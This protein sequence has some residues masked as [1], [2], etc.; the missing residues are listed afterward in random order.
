MPLFHNHWLQIFLLL[1]VLAWS[2]VIILLDNNVTKQLATS[3]QLPVA[4]RRKKG[5]SL[6]SPQVNKGWLHQTP[7]NAWD[8]SPPWHSN[9]CAEPQFAG[10]GKPSVPSI[11]KAF[12]LKFPRKQFVTKIWWTHSWQNDRVFLVAWHQ[13]S[14]L[15]WNTGLANEPLKCF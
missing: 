6:L 2:C 7:L 1:H 11:N 5:V 8:F 10:G 9:N 4:R 12:K 3:Y 14:L 13:E 15:D